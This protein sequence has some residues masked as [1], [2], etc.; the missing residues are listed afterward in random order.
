MFLKKE[1]D[2]MLLNLKMPGIDG[3]EVLKEMEHR[4]L[5]AKVIVLTAY[6][7]VKSAIDSAK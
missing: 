3:F 5:K 7:A 1:V 2:L 6:A 4:G